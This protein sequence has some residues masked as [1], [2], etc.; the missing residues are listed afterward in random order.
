MILS[1][2]NDLIFFPPTAPAD[3][4]PPLPP[5]GPAGACGA[6]P[7]AFSAVPAAAA[8][9]RKPESSEP[10]KALI[11]DTASIAGMKRR[12]MSQLTAS[13]LLHTLAV[14]K[15]QRR[16]RQVESATG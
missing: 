14:K 1:P 11:S 12:L 15:R 2:K 4:S 10:E 5:P 16:I 7:A 6:G 3:T 13:F 9:Y 8:K